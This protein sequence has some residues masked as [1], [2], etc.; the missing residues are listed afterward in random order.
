MPALMLAIFNTLVEICVLRRGPQDLPRSVSW[1]VL[2]AVAFAVAFVAQAWIAGVPD[3]SLAQAAL[4]LTLSTAVTA[5]LLHWRGLG[6]RLP[7]TLLGLFGTGVILNL[8]SAPLARWALDE[9]AAEPVRGVAF[10]GLIV[11][12]IW[13]LAIVAHIYRNAL[14]ISFAHGV[15]IAIAYFIV[16]MQLNVLLFPPPA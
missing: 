16:W 8:I 11:L 15:F 1:T 6:G 2:A 12:I 10:A 3:N 5:G 9:S 14:N 7:Q 4:D 13:N